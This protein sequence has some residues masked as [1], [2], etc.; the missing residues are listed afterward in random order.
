MEIL[1]FQLQGVC[2]R[3]QPGQS[4]DDGQSA[5]LFDADLDRLIH[6]F[7]LFLTMSIQCLSVIILRQNQYVVKQSKFDILFVK[8]ELIPNEQ[9][10]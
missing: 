1:C 5:F 3:E 9:L 7:L 6:N 4:F 2:V 10:L 8:T